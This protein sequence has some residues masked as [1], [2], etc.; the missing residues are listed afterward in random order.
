MFCYPAS[1]CGVATEA[2]PDGA[3]E[4]Y[5]T[6]HHATEAAPASACADGGT[7]RRHHRRGEEPQRPSTPADA[8]GIDGGGGGAAADAGGGFGS[9]SAAAGAAA[10]GGNGGSDGGDGGDGCPRPTAPPA[11]TE[12][13][14]EV[15]QMCHRPVPYGS[16]LDDLAGLGSVKEEVRLALLLPMRL[17]HLFQGI[18]QPARNFLLHGPPG[19]GK[20]MLVERI[21]AEAGATLLVLTPGAILSKWSGESEKQLRAVFDVAR[22]RQPCIVFMDEVDSLA[23][24]RGSGDDPIGR[25]LLNEL[26]VQMSCMAAAGTVPGPGSGTGAGA[27]AGA[28]AAAAGSRG[29][30]AAAGSDGGGGGGPCG[31]AADCDP[32][33]LR[34]FD[35]RVAVPL[36]DLA[37]RA[38]FLGAVLQRPEVAGHSLGGGEVQ[39]LAEKTEGYSGSDLAQLCREAAMQPVRELLRQMAAAAGGWGRGAGEAKAAKAAGPRPLA[40]SDFEWALRTVQ[41]VLSGVAPG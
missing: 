18:R 32:A 3:T 40:M 34:R 27:G 21:A 41:P 22:A 1:P 24:T 20:T 2:A 25:R 4:L 16:S 7:S 36:P 39:A 14:T 13:M 26:L 29:G 38:A 31:G 28:T 15:F 37:A 6:P 9:G 11:M 17:P 23:P 12:L 8:S 33:L 35:R 19:T 30:S 10:G 5:G